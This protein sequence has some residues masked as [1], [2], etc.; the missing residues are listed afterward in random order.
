VD[1]PYVLLMRERLSDQRFVNLRG[2]NDTRYSPATCIG[3]DMKVV[4]GDPDPKHVSTSYSWPE[5]Q[6]QREDSLRVGT[7]GVHQHNDRD[8]VCLRDDPGQADPFRENEGAGRS[9][10][11]ARP[12]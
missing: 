12:H 3:C 9:E 4:S 5:V 1:T 7:G 2:L 6:Y 10:G 8:R 11:W